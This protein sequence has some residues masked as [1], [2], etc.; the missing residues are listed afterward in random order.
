[1]PEY[2]L[3]CLDGNGS[4]TTVE[5][6]KAV[7]DAEAIM[8]AK[9]MKKPVNCELWQRSRMVAKIPAAGRP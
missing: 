7:N 1:M 5:K 3:Y 4:F 2:R 9:R 6:I 8:R